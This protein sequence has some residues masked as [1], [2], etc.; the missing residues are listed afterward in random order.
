MY[1]AFTEKVNVQLVDASAGK[2]TA[3]AKSFASDTPTLGKCEMACATAGQYTLQQRALH[4]LQSGFGGSFLKYIQ[5]C[6][7]SELPSG[8]ADQIA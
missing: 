7:K 6:L 4:N 1:S 2:A 8:C 5:C 3:P